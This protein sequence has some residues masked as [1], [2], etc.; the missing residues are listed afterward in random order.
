MLGNMTPFSICGNLYFVG[1]YEA[2]SHMIDTG[3]GLILIDTGYAE[4][5]DVIIESLSTLGYDVRDVKLVLISHGHGDHSDGTPKI[6]ERSGARVL[7][8]EA[9]V[10]Y[11]KGF[12][13]DGYLHDGDVVRLGNTEVLCLH[14][15][16]HTA[17]VIS[18]FFGVEEDGQVYR[19]GM[20]GGAGVNQLKKAFLDR[21]AEGP[22]LPL[23]W[24]ADYFGSVERLRGEQVDVFIGNHAW[25]NKTHEKYEQ[26]LA[27]PTKNPFIN[28]K[29][30][31][32]YLNSCDRSLLQMINKESREFFVN[33][34]HRGAS[35][36]LP[37]NTMAAFRAGIEMGA[38]GIETDV[39]L[40]SDGV[41]VL[42]HDS[43]L[44]RMTG[45]QGSVEEMTYAELSALWVE[46]NGVKD[47]I[48]TLEEFLAEFSD[49]ELTFAIELKGQGTEEAVA[50]LLRKYDLRKKCFV[51]SFHLEYI[52][53]FKRIAPEF[54]VG[55]L[56]SSVD[57][58]LLERLREIGAD[59]LCPRASEITPERVEAW[60][61]AGFNVRAWGVGTEE[62]MRK[63]YDSLA[64]GMTVNFPDKLA[65]YIA[66]CRAA[67]EA[68]EA[69]KNK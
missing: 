42:F 58:G 22:C 23:C 21:R 44:E 33:Y 34:A 48:P 59:E 39:R 24:R 29:A 19:A 5:A 37:E 67:E 6:V 57:D 13:P 61:R 52:E 53:K 49:R 27:D 14:T 15:P 25:N 69:E 54:R 46:K 35:E 17:G 45:V 31:G 11:L 38:N 18:F 65:A 66:E 16:G 56:T 51:T 47:K 26:K 3:D 9:D 62:A 36:Y 28:E 60:H 32:V 20:F 40:T 50:E 7:M 55:Y 41:A 1:T 10:R 63:A 2:S 68:T 4:T 64:N 12:T 30:W 8:H 43:S